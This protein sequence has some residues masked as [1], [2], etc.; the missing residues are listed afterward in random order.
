MSTAP[1]ES[2]ICTYRVAPGNEAKFRELLKAHWPKLRELG[3]VTPDPPLVFRGSDGEDRPFFVEIFAWKDAD[4]V[5]IA[6][7]HPEVLAIWEPM[8]TLTEARDGRPAMEFPHVV[9]VDL[10][11]GHV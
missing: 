2:V 9:P 4:A 7:D 8:A 6:H 1:A 11:H 3:V 5:Q 10:Q